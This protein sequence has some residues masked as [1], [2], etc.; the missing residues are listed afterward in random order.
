MMVLGKTS[1][2]RNSGPNG[3][4]PLPQAEGRGERDENEIKREVGRGTSGKK[5]T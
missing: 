4:L 2:I 1:F 5:L 3:P